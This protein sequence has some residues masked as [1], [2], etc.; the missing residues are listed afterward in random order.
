MKSLKPIGQSI[1]EHLP[2]ILDDWQASATECEPWHSLPLE[3]RLDNLPDVIS[4]LVDVALSARPSRTLRLAEVRTAAE[5][6]EHRLQMGVH[7]DALFTEYGLLRIA[8]TRFVRDH[9]PP[10]D[11]QRAV[12]RLS[13]STTIALAA[14]LWG[15]H[16]K[17]LEERGEWPKAVEQLADT[18]LARAPRN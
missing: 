11:A 13:T 10:P 7:E 4:T 16:R 14:S 3:A 12:V 18:W 6:G 1:K 9:F 5:H 2:E 15:Y 17:E 8:I